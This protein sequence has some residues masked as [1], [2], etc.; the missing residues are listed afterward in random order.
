MY[1]WHYWAVFLFTEAEYGQ[2]LQSAASWILRESHHYQV[3]EKSTL[4]VAPILRESH[5][6]IPGTSVA[7]STK[8]TKR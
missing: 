1:D 6:P 3:S 8:D 5:H 2:D 7:I 4:I